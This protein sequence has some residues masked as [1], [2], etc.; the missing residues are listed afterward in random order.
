MAGTFK[1]ELVSPERVLMSAD[2][3]E[4][5][6]P[7]TD[8]DF[9]VLAGH[10]PVVAT[11]RPGVIEAKTHGGA[12]TRIFIDGGFCEVDPASLTILAEKANDIAAMDK[13]TIAL[14][15]SAAEAVLNSSDATDEQMHAAHTAIAHLKW[16][17]S[18]AS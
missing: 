12:L 9:T 15:L 13:R 17:D 4:V 1:F 11:L 14:Q 3:D 7:G 6:V 8:G 18:Q 5:L 10:A 16:L 2:V